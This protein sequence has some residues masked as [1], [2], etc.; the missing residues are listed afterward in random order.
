[1]VFFVYLVGSLASSAGY[2]RNECIDGAV[3]QP[4]R[5]FHHHLFSHLFSRSHS[6]VLKGSARAALPEVPFGLKDVHDGHN[7]GI[8]YPLL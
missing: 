1:M 6:R 3:E 2:C 7:G 4:V 5:K 8:G